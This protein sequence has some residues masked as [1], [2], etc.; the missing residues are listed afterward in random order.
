[1]KVFK[2]LIY[3]VISI[4]C[5]ACHK[6]IPYTLQYL[7]ESKP[8]STPVIFSK[9]I[10][11]LDSQS[12]FGS[13]FN[14]RGDEFYFGVDLDGRSEIRFSKLIDKSWISPKT[15]LTDT[16]YHFNDPFL[17][18]DES[19]IY[20]ISNLPRDEFDTIP[21]IDI[22]YSERLKNKWSR[23]INAGMKINSDK[24]EYYI[25]F[26]KSGDMYFASNKEAEENRQHDF[27][28]YKSSFINNEFQEAIVESDSI[29]TGRYEADVFIS[30]DESYIIFCSARKS[31]FGNGDLYISFK[32]GN[33]IWR[34]AVNMDKP[35]NSEHHELCPFV[36]ADGKYL[37]Y[38]SNQ[39]IYWV[40]TDVIEKIKHRVL[41]KSN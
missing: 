18:P 20:Y 26:T 39:D 35:I 27:D 5:I 2:Y 41:T 38:T 28:I 24:N 9:N 23:P 10:I 37:F 31:G 40:S 11:T 1:M 15:I 16:S 34:N 32:D 33:G 21:D 3:F 4:V 12:E 22:W 25:S 17:S 8:D 14:K 6:S 19:R 30:P 29:N 13:V 36:S 7:G